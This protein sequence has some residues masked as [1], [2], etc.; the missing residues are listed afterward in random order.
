MNLKSNNNSNNEKINNNNNNGILE[1][2]YNNKK[3][4]EDII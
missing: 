1:Y 3:D 4:L 2:T